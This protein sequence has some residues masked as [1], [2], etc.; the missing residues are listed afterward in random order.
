MRLECLDDTQFL[1]R[2]DAGEHAHARHGRR[3]LGL[4]HALNRRTVQNILALKPGLTRD[5]AG[6]DGI[7]TGNHDYA[8]ARRLAFANSS[9]NG[10]AQRIGESRQAEEREGKAARRLRQRP[11]GLR[12]RN[13]KNAHAGRGQTVGF[14]GQ[15]APRRVV[16]AA[17]FGDRFRR[18]LGGNPIRPAVR[19]LPHLGYGQQVGL[20]PIDARKR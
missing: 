20:Q 10:G 6:G 12:F 16:E 2:H 3:K 4:T 14:G 5:C 17:Q 7:V 15:R 18:S 11:L 8:D 1:R 19:R 13:C 9:G